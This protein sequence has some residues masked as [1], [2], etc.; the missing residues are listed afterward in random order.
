MYNSLT[1]SFTNIQV[2]IFPWILLLPFLLYVRQNWM[3]RNWFW[4]FLFA[5]LSSFNPKWFYYSYAWCHHLY[6]ERTSFCIRLISKK[7]CGFLC[8]CLALL[9]SVSY[10]SF[11]YQSPSSSL[12]MVFDSVSSNIDDV[13]LINPLLISFRHVTKH[14]LGW[15]R[16]CGVRALW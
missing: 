6:E 8:F 5:G 7:P 11:L 10:F 13:L 4:Q 16:F 12:W 2:W 3:T 15:V 14:F 9:P 1:F